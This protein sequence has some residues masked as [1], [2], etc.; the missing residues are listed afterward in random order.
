MLPDDCL[1]PLTIEFLLS[2]TPVSSCFFKSGA[3]LIFDQ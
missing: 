3:L 2:A 1:A